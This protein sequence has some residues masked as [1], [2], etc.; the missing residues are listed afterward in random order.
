MSTWNIFIYTMIET[1]LMLLA[2][3]ITPCVTFLRFFSFPFFV[4]IYC[5]SHFNLL[6][7]TGEVMRNEKCLIN[8]G[9]YP[10]NHLS[11]STVQEEVLALLGEPLLSQ[12]PFW[13]LR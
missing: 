5:S 9:P 4:G 3:I 7:E 12:P 13:T 2:R 11:L 8:K 6:R 10:T 1:L